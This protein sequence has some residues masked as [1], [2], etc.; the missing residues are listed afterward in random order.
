[1]KLIKVILLS[2]CLLLGNACTLDHLGDPNAV[3]PDQALPNLVLNSMQRNL[4]GLFNT[5]STFGMQMT[6]LQNSGGS[7]YS[8]VY[9]PQSFDGSWTTAY[10]SILQDAHVLIKQADAGGLA[11]HAGMARII[12]AYSLLL[13]VDNF[14][15]VP[16][17]EA[18]KGSGNLNPAPD[19]DESIYTVILQMLDK[20]KL[21]LSTPA[22]ASGGYLN[23]TAPAP[24]DQF[25]ANNYTRWIKLANTL[26]LKM[27]LNL[28]LTDAATATT[29]INALIT[30]ASATGGLISAANENFVFRYGSNIVDPDNRHPRFTATYPAGSGNY[31]SNWLMWHMFHGYNATS[32]NAIVGPGDP[33]MRFYF[34][35]QTNANSSDPNQ[36]RCVVQA[37]PDHYP[38]SPTGTAIVLNPKA[39]MPP[40]IAYNPMLPLSATNP[41]PAHAAW[42]RTF[43]YPTDRGY[44]GRDHVDPQGIPPDGLLRTMWGAYPAGG[45]FDAN[46]NAGVSQSIGMKGAGI[47]PI[48]MRSNVQFMLAEAALYLGTV[49]VARTHFQNGIQNSM[50]DVRTWSVSGTYG[51]GA[52]SA[53]EATTIEAFFPA[54]TYA[55]DVAVYVASALA[56]F[57]AQVSNDDRMNYIA[58]EHWIAT[59]GNGVEAYNLYRRTGMPTGMQPVINS[60]PGAFPR[61][62]WYPSVF[63]DLNSSIEQ[64]ANLEG[65]IFWDTNASDLGF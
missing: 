43:C 18:F 33:R 27:Y 65:T 3:Q 6:R 35:R 12:S 20:A 7:L 34:Y 44:W 50:D 17:S 52:A 41:D 64:K 31:M 57:D 30:D 58:R 51:I 56:A 62:F 24:V 48:M 61:S 39:G 10:A 13:M 8:N 45:R 4:A 40:G 26:K 14:G 15:D 19:D 9:T 54:A 37:I 25:Y 53:S 59:F 5:F 38:Q 16:F 63:A 32:G 2:V 28:R 1:M 23:G 29:E 22:V 46:V 36:I 11:R 21:D 42:G 49:G 60:A 55:A 47:Q